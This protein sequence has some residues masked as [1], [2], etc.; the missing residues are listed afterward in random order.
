MYPHVIAWMFRI[1]GGYVFISNMFEVYSSLTG[2]HSLS[3]GTL[4]MKHSYL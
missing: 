1:I 3:R 4:R 2:P